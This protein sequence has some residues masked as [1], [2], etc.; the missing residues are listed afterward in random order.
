M[1]KILFFVL[2][3]LPFIVFS[4]GISSTQQRKLNNVLMAVSSLYVDSI[5]DKKVVEN[6]IV[7]LLK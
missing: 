2:I 7:S 1:K 4:Q 6:T 5:D 3:N